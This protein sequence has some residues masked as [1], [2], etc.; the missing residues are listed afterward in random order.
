MSYSAGGLIQASDYNTFVGGNPTTTANAFNTVWATG[1]T[2]NGWGQTAVANVTAG[3]PITAAAWNSLFYNS[4][5][6]ASHT[7]ATIVSIANVS[8]GSS[9]A[10]NS[11]LSNNLANIYSA[12]GNAAAQGS[13]T[14]NTVAYGSTWSDSLT[15]TQ[16]VTFANGDAA[17]YFFNA[18]GQI[19]MTVSHA[20]TTA[21]INALFNT[22]CTNVGTVVISGQSSG[23][24]TIAGVSYTGV[25]KVGG[26]GNAPSPYLTN[27]GYFALTT[28]NANI[29]T[30][31]ATGAPAG[32]VSS[33]IR[34][35][36]KSNGV[37]G[38]NGDVGNVITIYTVWDE[39]PNGLTVGTGSTTTLTIVPPATTYIAN[40][41]G[42][43]TL[44]GSAT[45]V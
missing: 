13:T 14:A 7:G 20:N 5:N 37:Q 34:F 38:S 22:L 1:G 36:V 4:G 44:A 2:A 32:Y 31:T 17:R 18:G 40:T 16:T 6:A 24:R 23:S 33:F 29:F 27:N 19:K 10:F 45:G 21:G 25:Q 9:I 28:S 15:V 39:V 26:G 8:V 41:W 11:N 43:I 30:Q 35:L 42:T 3:N 12:R